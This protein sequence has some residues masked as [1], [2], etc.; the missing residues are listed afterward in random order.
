M[1]KSSESILML[2]LRVLGIWLLLSLLMLVFGEALLALL[3]PYFTFLMNLWADSYSSVLTITSIDTA[4]VIQVTSTITQ[5]VY[6]DTIPV[7]PPGHQLYAATNVVHSYVPIVI[8]FTALAAWQV[9][10]KQERLYAFMFAVPVLLIILGLMVP[11]L[12]LGHIESTLLNAAQNVSER[13]LTPP[14]VMQWVIFSE[15]GGRWL[16][17]IVGALLCKLGAQK[18]VAYQITWS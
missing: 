13:S 7:A 1:F 5:A 6:I 9:R 18:L 4:R 14:Y 17:P 11:P 2:T 12:L 8:L 16:F 10:S 15:T 3:L